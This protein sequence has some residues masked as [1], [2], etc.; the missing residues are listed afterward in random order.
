MPSRRWCY[1]ISGALY[2]Q[3]RRQAKIPHAVCQAVRDIGVVIRTRHQN[4]LANHDSTYAYYVHGY[5]FISGPCD[6]PPASR[7]NLKE[8]TP[9]DRHLFL[10]SLGQSLH[11]VRI[12]CDETEQRTKGTRLDLIPEPRKS[13][14]PQH[15]D[16]NQAGQLNSG[17]TTTT[18]RRAAN[19]PQGRR[20][21]QPM[22]GFL[23]LP[24]AFPRGAM[25][26]PVSW[27]TSCGQ[28]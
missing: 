13:Q 5:E 10:T 24:Y 25:L 27:P 1:S 11:R 28:S 12:F 26:L 14:S 22:Q 2:R 18:Q 7:A 19:C 20:G 9:S 17:N 4:S 6:L 21:S 16:Q 15:G 8:R 23:S 3:K